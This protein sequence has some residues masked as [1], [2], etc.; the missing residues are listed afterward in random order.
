MPTIRGMALSL[1]TPARI[2]R[3]RSTMT[4]HTPAPHDSPALPLLLRAPWLAALWGL[5][6]VTVVAALALGRIRVPRV[7]AGVVVAARSGGDSLSLLLLLPPSARAYVRPG[8][9]AS[10]DTGGQDSLVLLVS[11]VSDSLLDAAR[12]R[13]SFHDPASV[14]AQLDAPKLV[15]RLEPCRDGR[16]LPAA[17]GASYAARARL[18]TRTLASYAMPRP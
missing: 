15:A 4:H 17:P 14:V 2:A 18:G 3:L 13:R 5:T 7:A 10:L 1:G 11:S 9:L 8:Q 12:A 6:L 16:C